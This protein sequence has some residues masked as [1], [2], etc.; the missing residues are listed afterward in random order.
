MEQQIS[1][2]LE[3]PQGRD[4]E[5]GS[6]SDATPVPQEAP[7]TQVVEA[8][9]QNDIDST[10]NDN[11][12]NPWNW[13]AWKKTLQVVMLSSTALLSLVNPLSFTPAEQ[14]LN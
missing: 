8:K 7:S 3:E 9:S 4:L 10:W 5:S 11:P 14:L 12:A 2:K 1:V 13:P 6:M